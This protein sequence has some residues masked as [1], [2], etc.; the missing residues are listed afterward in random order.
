MMPTLITSLCSHSMNEKDG[1][2]SDHEHK[3]KHAFLDPEANL[4]LFEL[5]DFI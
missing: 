3:L 2:Q 5:V 1:G 4:V